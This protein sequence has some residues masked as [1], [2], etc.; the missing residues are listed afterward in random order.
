MAFANE[1]ANGARY[2]LFVG[3]LLTVA[4]FGP[5]AWLGVWVFLFCQF[6]L[7]TRIIWTRTR[8]PFMSAGML[9]AAIDAL[10]MGIW[11]GNND[12]LTTLAFGHPLLAVLLALGPALLMFSEARF[13]PDTWRRVRQHDRQWTVR[14]ILFFRHIPDLRGESLAHASH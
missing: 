9:L 6:C 5:V 7:G 13:H 4:R 14:D 1:A 3:C 8:L 12:R 11:L 2:G 10:L